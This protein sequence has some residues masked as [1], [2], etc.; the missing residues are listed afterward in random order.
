[1]QA[2]KPLVLRFNDEEVEDI[3]LKLNKIEAFVN[4]PSNKDDES[5]AVL[6]AIWDIQRKVEAAI[7]RRNKRQHLAELK[8]NESL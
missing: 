2:N 5:F 8:A 7:K 3:Q 6:Q 1:M 4:V